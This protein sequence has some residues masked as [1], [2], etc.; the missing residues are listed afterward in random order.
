MLI[1]QLD[2]HQCLN[3]PIGKLRGFLLPLHP[4][5]HPVYTIHG[6]LSA[7]TVLSTCRTLLEEHPTWAVLQT[8][9][10]HFELQETA[11]PQ[12]LT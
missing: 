4:R 12:V 2:R 3:Y 1:G 5:Q 10:L 9:R 7:T 11:S 6:F 8:M